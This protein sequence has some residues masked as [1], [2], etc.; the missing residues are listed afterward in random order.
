MYDSHGAIPPQDSSDP[1]V[2]CACPT[3]KVLYQLVRHHLRPPAE[4]LCESCHQL[5]PVA[6]EDDWLTYRRV[7][8]ANGSAART[9][10]A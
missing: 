2:L 6:D 1:D 8:S 4:P 10:N 7:N 5:L 9:D 3:C